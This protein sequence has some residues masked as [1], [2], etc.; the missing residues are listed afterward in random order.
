MANALNWFE[1]P[2]LDVQRANKFYGALYDAPLKTVDVHDTTMIILPHDIGTGVGG[3][4]VKAQGY[5][6]A[7]AMGPVI[8]LN[9]GDDLSV[10]LGRVEAAGGKIVLTKTEI[11]PDSGYYAK[12]MDTEGNQVGLYSMG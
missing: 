9:G 2:M 5:E 11:S 8:Y 3:A 7:G 10:M 6:P 12:F 4:L 1:I